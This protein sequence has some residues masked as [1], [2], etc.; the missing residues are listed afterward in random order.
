VSYAR[1]ML[2]QIRN[3]KNACNVLLAKYNKSRLLERPRFR[4]QDNINLS[5][6][7]FRF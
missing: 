2:A 1:C 3:T 5:L 4:W 7:K 6:K